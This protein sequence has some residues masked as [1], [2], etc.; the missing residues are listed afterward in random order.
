M[1]PPAPLVIGYSA[2]RRPVEAYRFGH[3][4]RRLVLIGGIRGSEWNTILL[5]HQ[6]VDFF[7]THPETIPPNVTLIIIPAANPDGQARMLGHGGRFTARE[8]QENI[9]QGDIGAGRLNVRE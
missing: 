8:I 5:A 6:A 2:Q 7:S 3:G 1:L 9:I 4:P